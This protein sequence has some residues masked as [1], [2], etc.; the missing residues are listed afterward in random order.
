MGTLI[1]RVA[2]I[3]GGSRGLGLAIAQSFTQEGA[4]VVIASRSKDSV[5]LA[6]QGLRAGGGQAFG[7]VCNVDNLEQV[8]TLAQYA[9]EMFGRIDIW[10]NNAGL[11]CPTGPTAHIPPENVKELFE[12]N[13]LGVYHGSFVAMQYF[14]PQRYG[15][16]I[17]MLGKGERR[18]VPLHN[19]Y[20]SSKAWVRNFTKA[21]AK[22]YQDSGVGVYLLNPGLVDTDMLHH[23]HFIDGYQENIK[24]FKI[25]TRMWAKPPDIAAQKAV[26]LASSDT[27]GRTG[28]SVNVMT[29]RM[30]LAGG[31][32]ELFN[33]LMRRP[34]PEREVKVSLIQPTINPSE[35]IID[36]AND[37]QS[38]PVSHESGAIHSKKNYI[39]NL[40]DKKLPEAI[41][42]KAENLHRMR[43]KKIRVPNAYICSWNA[44]IDYIRGNKDVVHLLRHELEHII[45]PGKRYAI[46]SS[47]NIED[48]L[49]HS[50]AG[51]FLSVLNVGGVDQVLSS[52]CDI[53]ASTH[54]DAITSYLEQIGRESQ[55]LKM[56]V[57]IQEMVDAVYSGVAFSRNPITSSD[58]IVIEV[59]HGSGELLVQEGI[60]PHRWVYKWNQWIEKPNDQLIPLELMKDV[61]NHTKTISRKFKMDVDLEWVY[62]GKLLYWV[63]MRDITALSKANVYSNRMAKEMTPG[64]VKPLVWSVIVPIKGGVWVDLI[65]EV[66]GKNDLDPNSL[67][68]AFYYRAYHNLGVFG[69]VFE[70]L[71]LPRESL[72]MMM[73]VA[74]SNA[75]KPRMKPSARTIRLLPKI[76]SF[77]WHKWNFANQV[78]RDYPNLQ[79]ELMK[80]PVDQLPDLG[81]KELMDQ[82]SQIA[83]LNKKISYDTVII[84]LLMQAYNGV[85]R[86]LLGKQG[87]DF[88]DFDLTEG[89]DELKQYDPS[90]E[91][92]ILA[93][94]FD[95]LDEQQKEVIR[96]QD[97]R[98]FQ[99]L[100]GIDDFQKQVES[101]LER[102]GHMS[103]KT[104]EFDCVPWREN[105]DLILQLITNYHKVKSRS[106]S[107]I[108]WQDLSICGFR[109]KM[110]EVFYYRARKFRLYREMFSSLYTYNLLLFRTYYLA[111][112]DFFLRRGIIQTR[113]DIFYLYADEISTSINEGFSDGNI[114]KL[115]GQRK[116][117]MKKYENVLLPEIIYGEEVPPIILSE[118][119]K[120]TGIPTSRGYYTGRARLIREI[121]E[122]KKLEPGDVLVIPY[123][124]VSWTTLFSKAGAVIAESGGM[125]S[126]SSIIARE[127]NIPAVVS[128]PG[129]MQ[130]ADD[131]MVSI[132]GYKGEVLIHK[133][134]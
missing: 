54:T 104:G 116:E 24:I 133:S 44:Y 6:V 90:I 76:M 117:E 68:K 100:S 134:T 14:V 12:T 69:S 127:Y 75:G 66:I 96:L 82:L 84:I 29:P 78:E 110:L 112:G 60:T 47:S 74:P 125:L 27:D 115:V 28:I 13:I 23:L 94:Q 121:G 86:Y 21:L 107:N 25:V 63:Q 8:H 120:L 22:E 129:A 9:I 109:G 55:D 132:D 19:A 5:E 101:F 114:N 26:W 33:R 89:M 128:V 50:F 37:K 103:D 20:A 126:H 35:N 98:S 124:D 95:K 79:S 53:W 97:Y 36:S 92:E 72:E 1:D 43:S 77:L 99:G 105:P 39:F 122:F 70:S 38:P 91:I 67:A 81:T 61:V 48:H 49:D 51:Q 3:T 83:A 102:F 11:S 87:V 40:N 64:L 130:L 111:L 106:T 18:P 15:K 59:V 62:D 57:I 113:E 16:L 2:V 123:S 17:N 52:I 131:C 32:K 46:R 41:G 93:Q 31:V 58:E 85:L 30:M 88:Q 118:M 108:S 10:I 42:N 7:F 119:E 45:K 34:L 73:G 71:G 4:N 80:Y 56:A 65:T